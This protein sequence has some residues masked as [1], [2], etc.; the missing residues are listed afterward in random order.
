LEEER[1]TDQITDVLGEKNIFDL[2]L[3]L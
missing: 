3:R 2:V 1:C